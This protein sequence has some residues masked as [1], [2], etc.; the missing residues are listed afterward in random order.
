M[1]PPINP[2]IYRP[3]SG[4][5]KIARG[6]FDIC[7]GLL[8]VFIMMSSKEAGISG[9]EEVH[10]RQSEKVYNYFATHGTD[11]SALDTP[12]SHLKYY[13]QSFDNLTTILIRWF[14]IDDIYTFRHQMNGLAAWLC[15][16]LA[17]F[18]AVW[19]S[20]Y[21]AGIITLFL[22]ALSLT[23]L[24]HAQNNLKDI[25]FALAYLAGTLFLLRWLF[26]EKR[27]WKNATPLIFSIAF[28]IS[29]RPGGLLLICYLLLFAAFL[30]FK[31]YRETTKINIGTLKNKLTWIAA[32]LLISYLL[33]ILLWPYVL[34]NPITGFWKSYNVMTQFPTTIR[35]IFEGRL[36]W[37]DWMPWYYLPKLMLI[38]IPLVVWVGILAFFTVS[39]KFVK[40][41]WLKYAI[42]IFTILFPILFVIYEK[43][44]LYGSWRHFLFVYPAMVVLAAIGLWHLLNHLKSKLI[45]GVAITV[46]LLLAIHPLSFLVRTHPYYYLYYNQLTGGL[47]G[48]YGKYE[49]D[50]YYHSIRGGSEWLINYL[51]INHPN[52]SLQ[53]ATNFPADWFFRNEKRLDVKY[54]PWTDRSQHDWDYFVVANSYISPALLKNKMWPPKNSIKII[55]AD[56]IPICVVVKRESKQDFLGYLS[57]QQEHLEEAVKYFEEALKKECQDELIFF[58]FATVWYAVGDKVKAMSL[59][60]KGLEI[61]PENEQILMFQANIHAENGEKEKAA[62]LYKQVI[63]L[64]RKYFEAYP[65]LAKILTGEGKLKE[66]RALLKSC[67]TMNPGFKAAY[68]GLA[69]CYRVSD[70][71]V[72]K[73]YDELAK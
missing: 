61:N 27:N 33:G 49:T 17:G 56:D 43:S 25:P 51:K 58:N 8:L 14:D 30:E 2:I 12:T 47:K 24:G 20:G 69:D 40:Q 5:D 7:A 46:V 26:A 44:N 42:L 22:F 36:E 13:G 73:K 64:N 29:I 23:F 60:Q 37:S 52:D 57:I 10:F 28:C 68:A 39:G 1:Q 54:Y 9:D 66:A 16:V 19:L 53:V 45:W 55:Y 65:P 18:L 3:L 34:L 70:P 63:G 15:I 6:I 62:V 72:A 31:T 11:Q 50:Y 71:D 48:A 59:L 41:Q 67:L 4:K 35:Q 21:G 38:T 32:I